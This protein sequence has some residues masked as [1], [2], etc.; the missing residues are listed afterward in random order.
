MREVTRSDLIRV[1]GVQLENVVG[2]LAGNAER[3][4]DAMRRAEGQNAHVGVFPALALTG[5]PRADLVLRGEFVDAALDR[6]RWLAERSGHT[7]AVIGTVDRVPPRRSWDTRDRDVAISSAMACDGQL[8]GFYHKTLLP[9]YEVFNEA[10]NFAPGTDPGR[11]W[12]IGET[13]AGVVICEDSWSSD[14]PPED[15]SAAGARLMLVPNASP[16][17]REK[18]AGRQKLVPEVARRNGTPVVYVNL[19]GGQDELVFDGGSL[20]VDA[21]GELLYRARQF[22]PERFVLDVPLGGRR[23]LT[24]EPRTLHTPPRPARPPPPQ[25]GAPPPISGD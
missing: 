16:F 22:E 12:Q 20:V 14:G 4:L 3:I 23:T 15:Q 13:I 21:E 25:P 8:R 24:P 7:A 18:P 17:N 19:V 6:V 2:D 9:N 1:A 11:I 10:R 5:Y